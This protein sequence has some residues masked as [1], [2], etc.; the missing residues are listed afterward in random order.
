MSLTRLVYAILILCTVA[1]PVC[2]YAQKEAVDSSESAKSGKPPKPD[3]LYFDAMKAK[4][5]EDDKLAVSL[6]EQFIKQ[7]PNVSGA[8]YE[9]SKLTYGDKNNAKAE[10]Y[11]KKAIELDPA[12]KWYKEHLAS[13]LADRSAFAEA[14]AL[15]SEL[16]KAYPRDKTYPL[17]AAEYYEKAK[18]YE[19]AITYL[20]KAMLR[21]GPDEDIMIRKMQI[22]LS[23][24]NVD[25]A[26][27]V[28]LQ[29][30]SQEP[31]NGRYYKLLGDLYDNNKM[32]AKAGEVYEKAKKVIPGDPVVQ[33]GIAVHALNTGDTATYITNIKKAIVNRELDMDSQLK[34]LLD[35]L[36]ILPNDSA[37]RSQGLQIMEELV[38]QHPDES[39]VM[40]AFGEFLE[41]NEKHDSAVW[42][43]K[44]SLQI[45]SEFNVWVRFLN[46]FTDKPYAD[47]LIK[48]SEKFM[49]LYPAQV[50]PHYYN[51]IGHFNK[52]EYPAALKAINRA[53]DIQPEN[54][55]PALARLYSFQGDIYHESKQ[56]DLSDK[57]FDKT[58]QLDPDNAGVLNNYAYYLSERGKNLDLAEKMSK[59]SLELEPDR[60]TFLDTY[61]WILYKKGNYLKAKDYIEK[62]ISIAG[63][64]ADATLYDHLGNICFK[65]N[66]KDKAIE[67]WKKS[68]EIGGA[69]PL[70]DK[71]ISEGKLYE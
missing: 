25:K 38:R 12:N 8:Y 17:E 5:H 33:F 69:D 9:L 65:L 45:K 27:G 21:Y 67:Y 62:A 57:S 11:I 28:V 37:F 68:K 54:N 70:I 22:Y 13:L 43:Y 55:K 19:E 41:L 46:V 16:A 71:K 15:I 51:S 39:P 61:G 31:R 56:D 58:L 40:A 30:I 50:E 4:M 47:S 29:L 1:A 14:A 64:K 24:N 52:K 20:D 23:M 63:A 59:R 34:V 36:Q 7:R 60:G 10:E 44:R 18:N 32:P 53:I 48:Y 42:A 3:E 26:A 2:T 35:Y 49:R 6:L 66:E